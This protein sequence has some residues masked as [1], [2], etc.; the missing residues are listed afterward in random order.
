MR[1]TI[2]ILFVIILACSGGSNPIYNL[3][4]IPLERSLQTVHPVLGLRIVTE[5]DDNDPPIIG[6]L[7]TTEAGKLTNEEKKKYNLTMD[8]AEADFISAV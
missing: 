5:V 3:D 1:F 6:C 4:P 2:S 7:V 8:L